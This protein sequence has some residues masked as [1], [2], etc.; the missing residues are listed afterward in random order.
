MNYIGNHAEP[1]H[2]NR[3][4][5]EPHT[6]AEHNQY[7]QA[8]AADRDALAKLFRALDLDGNGSL[9]ANEI[10]NAFAKIGLTPTL[11]EVGAMIKEHDRD[12][13]GEL[14]FEVPTVASSYSMD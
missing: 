6:S 10:T 1:F 8:M 14:S 11:V 7:L 13:N 4:T 9:N 12:G 5:A 3:N 2:T